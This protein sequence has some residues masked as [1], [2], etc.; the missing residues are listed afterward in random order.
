MDHSYR[1]TN[2][3]TF[4][5]SNTKHS[6]LNGCKSCQVS[7][8]FP[9][10]CA[11]LPCSLAVTIVRLKLRSQLRL[12]LFCRQR[13]R[14]SIVC[15]A[16]CCGTV[17]TT[18]LYCDCS[19]DLSFASTRV[20][21]SRRQF[22]S[23]FCVLTRR[24]NECTVLWPTRSCHTFNAHSQPT[25]HQTPPF[26]P[27]HTPSSRALHRLTH[28]HSHRRPL[29]LHPLPPPPAPPLLVLL[30]PGCSRQPH[31]RPTRIPYRRSQMGRSRGGTTGSR[32]RP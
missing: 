7:Y 18:P 32:H 29:T 4:H 3:H 10:V 21:R 2:Q 30:H 27:L 6:Q 17:S 31:R 9:L 15:A 25:T 24:K 28:Y 14:G 11:V 19:S 5:H 8:R 16:V 26:H 12:S 22:K 13:R 20:Q 1:T 23:T